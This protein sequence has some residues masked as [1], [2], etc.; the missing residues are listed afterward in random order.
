MYFFTYIFM[1]V[2][3]GIYLY[4]Q[5]IDAA[6]PDFLRQV[7]I[8]VNWGFLLLG[9]YLAGKVILDCVLLHSKAEMT[10]ENM[11]NGILL[12]LLHFLPTLLISVFM[13]REG[14]AGR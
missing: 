14:F 11:R 3:I 12:S 4:F 10:T 9:G 8:W 1:C 5:W 6:M 13:L 2:Y 7:N